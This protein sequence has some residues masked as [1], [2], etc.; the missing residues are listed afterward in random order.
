MT[1]DT[2]VRSRALVALL[3]LAPVPS[4][5]VIV[6]M[7]VAPGP[8]GKTLFLIGKIWLLVFPAAWYLLVEKA[9]PSWSP[10]ENGGLGA[11][12]ASGLVLAVLIAGGAWL[13]NV[14][15]M[16]LSPLWTEVQKM[17]LDSPIAYLTAAAGW[18]F[19]NSLMEEYVYRWFVYRQCERLMPG[20]T[21]ILASAAIFTLHHVIAVSQYLDLAFTVFA[22]AGVF[23]GGV[24][25][26]WLYQRYRSIWPCWISHV[27]AD[28]AVFGI[29]WYLLFG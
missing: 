15:S 22:S 20:R 9:K 11:G 14:P 12:A 17:G 29:G 18:T 10:P 16:D 8:F 6:A 1:A 3:L 26:S 7:I 5:S 28:A 19:A 2:N 24:V 27:L 13:V 25:W 4:L 21:A 23:V